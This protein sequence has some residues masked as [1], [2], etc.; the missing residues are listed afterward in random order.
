VV[1]TDFAE[2]GVGAV[3]YELCVILRR[4]RIR[5][6]AGA[7]IDSFVKIEGGTGVAIGRGVHICSFAHI[8]TGGGSV[9]IGDYVGVASGARI[10]GGSN[11]PQGLSMSAAAPTEMQVIERKTTTIE[12]YAFVGTNATV[13]AGV[14]IGEGA[15]L[16]AGGVATKDIPAWEIW[17]G[18]PARKIGERTRPAGLVSG[19]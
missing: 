3:I 2:F 1:E 13:L 19:D 4:E 16:G 9:S 8:N 17:G 6:G 18:V 15:I 12:R 10:L 14:T 5:I 11:M 7:R